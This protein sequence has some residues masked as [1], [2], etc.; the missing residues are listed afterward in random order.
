MAIQQIQGIQFSSFLGRG[1]SAPTVDPL[2]RQKQAALQAPLPGALQ[3][4]APDVTLLAANSPPDVEPWTRHYISGP[5]HGSADLLDVTYS[6]NK[7]H[8]SAV[9]FGGPVS[10]NQNDGSRAHYYFPNLRSPGEIQVQAS[11]P[12][13]VGLRTDSQ[14]LWIPGMAHQSM[15]VNVDGRWLTPAQHAYWPSNNR[16]AKF[17]FGSMQ[18]RDIVIQTSSVAW[19]AEISVL[20]GSSLAPYNW[21]QATGRVAASF[22]AD[23]YGQAEIYS[24]VGLPFLQY[25]SELCGFGGQTISAIGGT[26]Y[27]VPNVGSPVE[28]PAFTD[29]YRLGVL[30]HAN[31]DVAVLMGGINDTQ[32]TGEATKA[33]MRTVVEHVRA[34][35]PGALVVAQTAWAPNEA[36][37]QNLDLKWQ[38]FR[39]RLYE[40][41]SEVPGPWILLDNLAGTWLTSKHTARSTARGPWQTGTGNAGNPKGD[42]NGDTWVDADGTHMTELG[43]KNIAEIWAG[44]YKAALASM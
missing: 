14:F 13:Q 28:Y 26:G 16:M 34:A 6:Y 30:T 29:P 23:S 5:G 10:A 33:A 3:Y 31:P 19:M 4:R 32:G 41:M 24:L 27:A 8:W 36:N 12:V 38:D 1:A 43:A 21:N 37:G 18:E 7:A 44:E 2:A 11:N 25:I 42:G 39:T 15:Q 20:E 17:D 40:V 35:L 22:I 9:D